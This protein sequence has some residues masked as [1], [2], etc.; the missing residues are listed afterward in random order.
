MKEVGAF[1]AEDKRGE[2]L[3][4]AGRGA[5]IIITTGTARRRHASCRRQGRSIAL[6]QEMP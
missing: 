6:K 3:E 4:L 5:E 1:E 2:L